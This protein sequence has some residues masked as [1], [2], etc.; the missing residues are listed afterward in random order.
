MSSLGETKYL[1]K[2]SNCSAGPTC[3]TSCRLTKKYGEHYFKYIKHYLKTAWSCWFVECH[4]SRGVTCA[5]V[6]QCHVSRV[7]ALLLTA[8]APLCN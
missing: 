4:V 5:S 8:A 2:V 3:V 1:R 7:Q 6:V